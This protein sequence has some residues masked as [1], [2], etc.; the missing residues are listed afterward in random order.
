MPASL[1]FLL[2]VAQHGDSYPRILTKAV[3]TEQ[4]QSFHPILRASWLL[5][6]P[7]LHNVSVTGPAEGSK[8]H[9]FFFGW[10]SM[11]KRKKK[12]ENKNPALRSRTD[13]TVHQ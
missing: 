10:R 3:S 9:A 13:L 5:N 2:S 11:K 6:S 1:A 7:S 12:E 8:V 4:Q